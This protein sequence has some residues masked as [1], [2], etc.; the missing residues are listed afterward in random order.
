MT[1]FQLVSDKSHESLDARLL[2]FY[3]FH[4]T[5]SSFFEQCQRPF[6]PSGTTVTAYTPVRFDCDSCFKDTQPVQTHLKKGTIQRLAVLEVVHESVE[7]SSIRSKNCTLKGLECLSLEEKGLSHIILSL[8][9]VDIATAEY[10]LS[11]NEENRST[12]PYRNHV[13]CEQDLSGLQQVKPLL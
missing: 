11:I 7:I 12:S 6:I 1:C 4:I 10:M 13:I 9:V 3:L 8:Y 2:L 5:L